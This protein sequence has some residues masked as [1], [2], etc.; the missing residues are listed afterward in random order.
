MKLLFELITITSIWTLGLTIAS[1]Y[2]RVLGFIREWADNKYEA[3]ADWTEPLIRCVICLPSIHAVI[4]Y[5]FAV[6]MGLIKHFS[7]S[8]ILLYP[9]VVMGSCLVNAIVYSLI[10]LMDVKIQYYQDSNN[11]KSEDIFEE[12]IEEQIKKALKN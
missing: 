3:G 6:G 9:L 1:Q 7:W 2:G 5:G 8:L 11:Y 4:G 12:N 10:E